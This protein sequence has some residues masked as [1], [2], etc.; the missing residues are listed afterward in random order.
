MG[1][2]NTQAGPLG[3]IVGVGYRGIPEFLFI[4]LVGFVHRLMDLIL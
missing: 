2:G 1:G 3:W 4:S